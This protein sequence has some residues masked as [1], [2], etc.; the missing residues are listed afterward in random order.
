MTRRLHA[1]VA[2]VAG[3]A[4]A[5]TATTGRAQQ[6]G[7]DLDFVGNEVLV[8]FA[9]GANAGAKAAARARIRG[10]T[11]EVVASARGERGDLE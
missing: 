2:I 8:Q 7:P 5:Q 10:Q 1:L 6:P 9:P 4:L 3:I 11:I